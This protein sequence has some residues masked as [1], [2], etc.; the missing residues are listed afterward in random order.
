MK[1]N[2]FRIESNDRCVECTSVAIQALTAFRKLYPNHRRRD[3][4][5]SIRKAVN[6]IESVQQ[7]DG[8]WFEYSNIISI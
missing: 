7:P 5:A 1:L 3:I 8:S 2:M 4:D 6:Y